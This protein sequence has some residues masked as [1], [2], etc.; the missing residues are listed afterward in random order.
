[1]SPSSSS[2]LADMFPE[3]TRGTAFGVMMFIGS[4]GACALLVARFS[5]LVSAITAL[6]V[7]CGAVPS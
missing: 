1:M 4:V 5:D 7:P 6:K 2:I 3:R